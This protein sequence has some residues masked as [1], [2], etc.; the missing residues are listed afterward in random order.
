MTIKF[1]PNRGGIGAFLKSPKMQANVGAR[2]AAAATRAGSGFTS[3]VSTSGDRAK[4]RVEAKTK[5][6][7]RRQARDHVLERVIGGGG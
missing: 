5:D 1:Q 3:T 4:A 7:K 2:G 6:A